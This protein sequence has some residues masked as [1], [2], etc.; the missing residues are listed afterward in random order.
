MKTV[1]RATC[2]EFFKNCLDG[3]L[4]Q[5]LSETPLE[6]SVKSEAVARGEIIDTPSSAL[7]IAA[8]ASSSSGV[9]LSQHASFTMVCKPVEFAGPINLTS[10][11]IAD[12]LGRE[13]ID[14]AGQT[15]QRIES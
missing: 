9:N 15:A 12:V 11:L 14:Q 1:T 6:R 13:L 4:L 10:D 7:C 2:Y 8:E 5:H 3:F